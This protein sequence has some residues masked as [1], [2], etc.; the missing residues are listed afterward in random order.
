[1]DHYIISGRVQGVGYRAWSKKQ[2]EKLKLFGWVRNLS[3]GRVEL[4]VLNGN[5]GSL[6]NVE[7]L[8]LKG[9]LLAS[10]VSVQRRQLAL[11]AVDADLLTSDAEFAILTT[12]GSPCLN[13]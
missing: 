13:Y 3:D 9:P 11:D 7:P 1:M 10:V 6:E 12:S 8:L 5:Q 4:L 2:L